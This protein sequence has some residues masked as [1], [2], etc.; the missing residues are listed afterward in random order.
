MATPKRRQNTNTTD[1]SAKVTPVAMVLPLPVSMPS[2]ERDPPRSAERIGDILRRERE[3][4]GDDLQQI[5]DFLCIRRTFLHAIETSNY[6]EF[7]ADAYIIGF[8]RS[9]AEYLGLN[10]KDAI[11]YYRQEMAGR[12]NTPSLAMPTPISEGRA[13]T[14]LMMVA[15]VVAVIVVYGI[16]YDISSPDRVSVE[17]PPSPASIVEAVPPAPAAQPSGTTEQ[18]PVQAAVAP[19]PAAAASVAPQITAPAVANTPVTAATANINLPAPAPAA[20]PVA[21]TPTTATAD[22]EVKPTKPV[23]APA[24]VVTSRIVIQADQASWVM[25]ADSKGHSIFDRVMK[26]GDIY[27]VPDQA[28]LTLT[29]GNGSGITILHDGIAMPKLTTSPSHVVRNIPLNADV[30]KDTE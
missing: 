30:N 15:A 3:R 26:A 12:R 1:S 8:L 27:N 21:A 20:A 24:R 28:G 29:T 5:A 14:T 22:P 16:W 13:P 10:G 2:A 25:I 6:E 11:V 17:V 4:R 19:T 23:V 9:Y 18:Q 7:P